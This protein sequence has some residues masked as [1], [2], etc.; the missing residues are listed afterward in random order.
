MPLTHLATICEDCLR[1]SWA[2]RCENGGRVN[3][4]EEAGKVHK[5][6]MNVCKMKLEAVL[7]NRGITPKGVSAVPQSQV[8]RNADDEQTRALAKMQA[9]TE[10]ST[11]RMK[12]TENA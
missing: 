8:F 5:E 6:I 7:K 3:F 2:R 4:E 11:R 9:S 1:R 12:A 10:L